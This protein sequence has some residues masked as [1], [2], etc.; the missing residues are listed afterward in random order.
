MRVAAHWRYGLRAISIVTPMQTSR[1]NG[2]VRNGARLL[3]RLLPGVAYPVIRG[4][5][6][7]TRFVLG[8]LA[9]EGGGASV[10]LNMVEPEQTTEFAR[11]TKNA[12]VVFDIGA[13]VGYYTVLAAKLLGH[14]GVVFSFEPVIRNVV[15]MNRHIA[16]NRI[17]NVVV[18]AAACSDATGIEL[19]SHGCNFA[20]GHLGQ[21]NNGRDAFPVPTVSV[22]DVARR[23]NAWPDVI[24]VD[25]E[26]AELAVL[27]G[28][29]TALRRARPTVFLSTHSDA[30]RSG[31]LEYL[32]N[33]GYR[34]EAL[35]KDKS[36]ASEFVAT[37]EGV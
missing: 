16:V 20:E 29:D 21:D 4:P 17:E 30:L 13:N 22:D 18:I 3:A 9:G 15:L 19:F 31:C 10:Y 14:Q 25:V 26:G 2:L 5:L 28:A 35:G 6:R 27:K 24:K 36:D 23:T 8:A 37:Y 12:H 33:L 11:V 34:Y 32:K 7:G 1:M